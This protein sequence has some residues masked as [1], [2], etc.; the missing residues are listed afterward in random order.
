M[1][2][3]YCSFS[4]KFCPPSLAS[5]I[6][7]ALGCPLQTVRSVL[8]VPTMPASRLAAA[9]QYYRKH[10][11]PDY[12]SGSTSY[13]FGLELSL[14]FSVWF[15]LIEVK[16]RPALPTSMYCCKVLIKWWKWVSPTSM[17]MSIVTM[18]IFSAQLI[19]LIYSFT[20]Q[21]IM[22]ENLLWARYC[23]FLEAEDRALNRQTQVPV[24]KELP[25]VWGS[26]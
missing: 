8:S 11:R 5:W 13:L 23:F 16:V 18:T 12:L 4:F 2:N 9:V 15:L 10:V 25:F 21:L 7:P 19:S 20:T 22:I 14:R 3:T 26:K 1:L 17:E 24:F 6:S